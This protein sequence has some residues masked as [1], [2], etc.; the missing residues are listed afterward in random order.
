[1]EVVL[2]GRATWQSPDQYDRYNR[3]EEG[4]QDTGKVDTVHCVRD[5]KEIGSQK[6]T[7]DATHNPYDDISSRTTA[8]TSHHLVGKPTGNETYYNP[9]YNTHVTLSFRN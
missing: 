8:T 2:N 3:T 9:R 4:N 7:N 1:M 5:A 6:A